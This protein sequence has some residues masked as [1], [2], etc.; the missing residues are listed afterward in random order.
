MVAG[1]FSFRFL[2]VV[3]FVVWS[4]LLGPARADDRPHAHGSSS[5][6]VE[7]MVVTAGPIETATSTQSVPAEAFELRP[8]ES[9]G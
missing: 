6:P 8:I 4:A 1:G 7:V 9:G 2:I 5:T 3:A